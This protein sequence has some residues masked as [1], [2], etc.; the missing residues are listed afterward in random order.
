[1]FCFI[2]DNKPADFK[3]ECGKRFLS[4]I[5][6]WV[7]LVFAGKNLVLEILAFWS[8]FCFAGWK[9]TQNTH[10]STMRKPK[11]R[12]R[13]KKFG[14][15]GADGRAVSKK[16]KPAQQHDIPSSGACDAPFDGHDGADLMDVDEEEGKAADQDANDEE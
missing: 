14:N 12:A 13:K 7:F 1:M 16:L 4:S 15:R 2:Y 3:V 8:T 9:T 11:G 10:A 6:R 5:P